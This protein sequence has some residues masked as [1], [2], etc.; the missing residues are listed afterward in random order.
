MK[1]HIV[2]FSEPT[3]L[4]K[5]LKCVT[6]CRRHDMFAWFLVAVVESEFTD[7]EGTLEDISEEIARLNR[8]MDGY[9]VAIR[10]VADFH[11]TCTTA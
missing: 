3:S 11:R 8:E 2:V 4:S 7:N 10:T 5:Q 9:L 6:G 1:R